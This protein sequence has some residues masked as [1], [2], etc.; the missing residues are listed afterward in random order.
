MRKL[1]TAA[2]LLLFLLLQT[3]AWSQQP[4]P[5]K[6][7]ELVRANSSKLQLSAEDA[8]T[9]LISSAYTDQQTGISYVYLQQAY[10]SIPVFNSIK[11]IIFR[12]QELQYSSGQFV[13]DLPAKAGNPAASLSAQAAIINAAA[14]L[15]LAQPSG[16]TQLESVDGGRKLVFSAANIAKEKIT[17]EL[18][19]VASPDD[20]VVRLA[21]NINIDVLGSPDW[22]NVRVD[23]INGSIL[24]KDNWTVNEAGHFREQK[25]AHADFRF[26]ATPP[27]TVATA[28]YYV[29]PFPFE[30]PAHT[31][32]LIE[33]QP[34]LKA[35]AGN[36]AT[37]HGWH[38]DG[39]NNYNITR[40]NN[41]FAYL[42][43]MNT[44]AAGGTTNVP[45]TSSTAIPGLS[46][47]NV[48]NF[49]LQ[50]GNSL[51][52]KAAVTNLFYWNNIIHDVA[53]QY[54]FNEV[55]GNFQA[56]NMGRGGAGNDY[57]QAEAQDA[58]GTNNAN[59]AT[60]S[61]GSRPRMQMYIFTGGPKLVVTAPASIAGS[62]GVVEGVF[63]TANQ[64][65]LTGAVTGQ[66]VYYNDPT[67]TLHEACLGAP[68]NI[69]TG[70]IALINRG[71]CNFTDKV[72]AAQ[73]AGAIGVIMVNNVPGASIQMG[74]A[75]NTITI[76]AVM[77]SQATGAQI[78]AQ[79]AN[80]VM[81]T[82]APP[83]GIDGDYDNGIVV[84][85]YGHGISNRLT[86]GPANAS[87]LGNA[88]QGG[89][90]WSD[91]ITLMMTTNWATAQL[92]DGPV[93]RPMGTYAMNQGATGTGIRTFPYSTNM[94]VNP[95]TYAHMASNTE[96][97]FTGEIWCAAL[98]DMTWNII[99][100]TGAIESNLYNSNA[101]A[102]NVIAMRLVFEGMRL[103]PC[104]PGFLDARNA[105][106]AADSILYN[107]AYKCAIWKAFARRGMG[108]SAVQGLS[109]VATDQVAAFD[110]P[111]AVFLSKAASPI[112]MSPGG[113]QQITVSASCQC[114]V[115]ANTFTIRDT[116]PAGFSYV[117]SSGGVLN[118]N[119]V[120]FSGVNFA[121]EQE[122]KNF[123]I[124][125]KADANGC[126]MDT[127]INDNR[128]QTVGGLTS[129]A[130]LGSTQWTNST[131]RSKS[132]SASWH[133]TTPTAASEFSLTSTQFA[134]SNL[135]VL[136]FWHY[137]VTEHTFDGGLVEFS[138][139]NG[140]TWKDAGPYM[141]QN[142]YNTKMDVNPPWTSTS[143]AF[144][145]VSYAQGNSQFINTI[146]D[147]STFAGQNMRIR[148][149]MRT[150]SG[151]PAVSEGWFIDDI[152]L[153]NGCGAVLKAGLYNA[154]GTRIDSAAQPVFIQSNGVPAVI[155]SQPAAVT[156]C[157]GSTANFAII[158]GGGTITYQW[159][160]STNGGA[161]FSNIS[162]ATAPTLA[163]PGVTAADNGHLY[164]CVIDNGS[165]SATSAP[166][167][168]TIGTATAAGSVAG[169]T[170]C[171]GAKAVFNNNATG[172]ALTYQWQVSSDG[173]NTFSNIAGATTSSLSLNNVTIAQQGN[174]YRVVVT[175]A[176]G[177]STSA[178]GSLTVNAAPAITITNPPATLCT[179]DDAVTLSASQPG[180]AWSG[181]GMTGDKFVPTG[182]TP[183][184]Y[185]VTYALTNALGCTGSATAGIVV[186]NC[187]DRQLLLDAPG[188]IILYPNPNDGR[189][190]IKFNTE[191]YTK[192]QMRV[193][194]SD[195]K[196]V[197]EQSING[198][199][200]GMVQP[201]QLFHLASD[202][203]QLSLYDE[204]TGKEKTFRLMIAR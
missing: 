44:N 130:S 172:T 158:A 30:S 88:E 128:T 148:F 6:I 15:K 200:Y 173:G 83:V 17:A 181:L 196:L 31:A 34:W 109:S 163:I 167:L 60:P 127:A 159:Q 123:S 85:E 68:T 194:A 133:A 43:L 191:R 111:S 65:A 77:V 20:A 162:G 150:D 28:G 175:G 154:A 11:T 188:A 186:T 93:P 114:Q 142:G 90:G 165:N 155:Q 73:N 170:A 75:D 47:S 195:A 121:Q 193:Y 56:D 152:M 9:A 16:L 58:S 22:W 166:A 82:L 168:L 108:L 42:D 96:V 84:H 38:F 112:I 102:G 182:L 97:H 203:Y 51:N 192:L 169:V 171:A 124:T 141:I 49:S 177:T 41:V 107:G 176:C 157:S 40:G 120:S 137:Y 26:Y 95:L 48:P 125:I 21:W 37:T 92:T 62:Y 204:A 69:L 3:P 129:S 7:L 12:N 63:S 144:S 160:V 76:P 139:D 72:K 147:L 131:V 104:R 61:D 59:F 70:K 98:W 197:H 87:C 178:A 54:G 39:N 115:P 202:V 45:D 32:M 64:L 57:V 117:G 36:A 183:G 71:N 46:F 126:F 100:Q 164:R 116:I 156:V 198:I 52:R 23:A 113:Q 101:V 174:Q 27:P 149:R 78:A 81:A 161:S 140:N 89:E 118:G 19:W 132:P 143:R 24:E 187:A 189:F 35:G 10:K 110:L 14:H 153:L 119:V 74:G 8:A 106:L 103:Q 190:S 2:T 29:V 122:T 50:P 180:G 199:I 53:Y 145:G 105:I 4:D 67:G 79:L 94:S 80:N 13:F 5:Q 184:T 55:S 135:S 1:Y 138:T 25:A 134:I 136:S 18:F 86:G 185:Q 179:S 201:V 91:Y 66:V 146:V 151:N 33:N 99:Q